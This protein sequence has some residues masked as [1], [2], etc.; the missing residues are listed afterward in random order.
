MANRRIRD[1]LHN[2]I[3][4]DDKSI[5]DLLWNY[6]RKGGFEAALAELQERNQPSDPRLNNLQNALM[7]MFIDMDQAFQGIQF[8]FSHYLKQSIAGFLSRFDAIFTLNQDLLLE[9]HYLNDNIMLMSNQRWN[10]YNLPGL[11]PLTVESELERN[12]GIWEPVYSAMK[13]DQ[14]SQPYFKLHGSSNWR[15]PN[16]GNLLVLGG[17]KPGIISKNPLLAFYHTEFETRLSQPNTRLM[18][19]GCSFT[20]HH[21]NKTIINAAKT[22]S[23]KLFIIDPAGT[24]VIDKNQNAD[25]YA[26]DELIMELWPVLIGGSRRGLREIFGTDRVEYEKVMRFFQ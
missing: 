19:I 24:N 22:G 12:V 20:D 11:K 21:I 15:D 25:I 6:R 8:E 10:G 1:P 18:V 2:L 17:N 14:R 16:S 26:P 23:L 4:F 7:Q 3:E 5:R 13:L 9:R